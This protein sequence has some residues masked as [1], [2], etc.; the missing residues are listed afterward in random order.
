MVC[1]HLSLGVT[2]P[3]DYNV[4]AIVQYSTQLSQQ[5]TPAHVTTVGYS[6]MSCKSDH[7]IHYAWKVLSAFWCCAN[8][9][10]S[11]SVPG[12]YHDFSVILEL[13]EYAM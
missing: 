3:Q 7:V 4:M 13:A 5:N 8:S 11:E 1:L 6:E 2:H 9:G 12:Q 10:I